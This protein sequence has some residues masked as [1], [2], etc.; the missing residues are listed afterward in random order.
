MKINPW[1]HDD[2][3]TLAELK[4]QGLT[5]AECAQA[6]GRSRP[7]IY[8]YWKHRDVMNEARRLRADDIPEVYYEGVA[9]YPSRECPYPESRIRNYCWWW[10][11]WNDCE[12]GVA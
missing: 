3:L 6:M 9:A 1:T 5:H 10:A 12:R 4:V 8:R 2:S 11:G 7:T